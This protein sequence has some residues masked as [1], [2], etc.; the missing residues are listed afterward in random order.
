MN[1]IPAILVV[2]NM[3]HGVVVSLIAYPGV[4][5]SIPAWLHTFVEIDDETF[6]KSIKCTEYWLSALSKFVQE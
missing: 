1:I 5:S 6:F 4:V 2:Q 3:D